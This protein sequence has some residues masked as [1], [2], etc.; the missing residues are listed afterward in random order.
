[1]LGFTNSWVIENLSNIDSIDNERERKRTQVEELQQEIN[2]LGIQIVLLSRVSE[3]YR[4][5]AISDFHEGRDNIYGGPNHSFAEVVGDRW[6]EVYI[7]AHNRTTYGA[8]IGQRTRSHLGD[9]YPGGRFLGSHMEY[10]H[11][12]RIVK[13]WVALGE[14]P[15]EGKGHVW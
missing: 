3:V 7:N 8:R 14:F 10:D 2:E 1:M 13:D 9:I 6:G 12:V 4:G 11:A 5:V 15:E